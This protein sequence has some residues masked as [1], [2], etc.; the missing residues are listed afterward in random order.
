MGKIIKQKQIY[1]VK[2]KQQFK[3]HK[4]L[5]T[6]FIMNIAF[7]SAVFL[8]APSNGRFNTFNQLREINDSDFGKR[9]LDTIAL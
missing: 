1:L 6:L 8:K 4:I 3:M 7:T 2:T 9:I 5:A